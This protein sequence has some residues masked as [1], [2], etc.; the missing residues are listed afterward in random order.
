[1][2]GIVWKDESLGA[3]FVEGEI[4]AELADQAGRL[5]H[6]ADRNRG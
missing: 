5:S 1:M 4:P 2:I 3:E 6:E